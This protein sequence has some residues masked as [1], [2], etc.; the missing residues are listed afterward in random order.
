MRG[1]ALKQVVYWLHVLM[2]LV[3]MLLLV[4]GTYG[5]I[6]E[7]KLAYADGTI[8]ECDCSYSNVS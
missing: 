4:G 1:T 2:I 6:M 3:G 5:V 7:I 8:G